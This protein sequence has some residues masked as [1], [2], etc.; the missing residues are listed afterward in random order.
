MSTSS[1]NLKV[2]CA[3]NCGNSP[4]KEL[5]RDINISF[6]KSE[7][8]FCL[9]WMRDDIIW[10]IIGEEQIQGKSEFEKT[11][12][13]RIDRSV[14]ELQIHNIITHGNTGSVNGN[15]IL[16]DSTNVAF[17][18]V[19]HFAGFGKTAKIKKITSYIIKI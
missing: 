1:D 19:Y 7:I 10:D 18:D 13:R 4:K 3:E 16:S 6:A 12:K 9:G 11:W 8:D 17:C 15:I 5:L 14:E 2:H